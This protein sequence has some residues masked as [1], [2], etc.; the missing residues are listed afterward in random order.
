MESRQE[1]DKID[2]KYKF[3]VIFFNYRDY[4]P[5]GQSFIT[6]KVFDSKWAPVF[7]DG[8]SLILLKRNDKNDA[9]IK[10]FEIPKN[11]FSISK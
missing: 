9:I 2:E 4:T 10:K 8:Q 11:R 6:E 7:V 1:F 3:N 5:W